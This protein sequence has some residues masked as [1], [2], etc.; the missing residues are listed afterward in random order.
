MA[1]FDRAWVAR[2]PGSDTVGALV[3][4][5]LS[6]AERAVIANHAAAC[7]GCH[8]LIEGL[9]ETGAHSE[10]ASASEEA[11]AGG[12]R[13]TDA[14]R[15]GRGTRVGRYVIGERLGAGG[16][17]IVHA[18]VDSELHRRV[19]VKLLRP[20]RHGQVS[21]DGRER[22]MREARSLARLSH[23]NV[24]TVFDVGEHQ[25]EL[26]IAMELVDGGS[27]SAWLRRAPRSTDEVIARM[28]DAGRG[29]AAAH[30]A[31]IVHRDIKPDNILVGLDGRVRVTD[32]GL[33]QYGD[34]TPAPYAATS[35]AMEESSVTLTRTGT[36]MGTPA[37]MA[38]EQRTRGTT[39][40][41]TDQWSFCATLH[42]ALSG[43][44]PLAA[45]SS[46]SA[47]RQRTAIS[48][49]RRLPRWVR[50]IVA[51]GLRDDP[52]ARWPSMHALVTALVRGRNRRRHLANA[53]AIAVA[54]AGFAI[55]I[56][57]FG[58]LGGCGSTTRRAS[59]RA[60]GMSSRG[61]ERS[62]A[63]SVAC[64]PTVDSVR[65][66]RLTRR[67]LCHPSSSPS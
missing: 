26:F 60:A 34:A 31:G 18:A 56:A 59:N 27:L 19:A 30:E 39:D 46:A 47:D 57:L 53:S 61:D 43:A 23:P 50:R 11:P 35:A 21:S 64:V 2:C 54:I 22:L 29:L 41:R 63:S 66:C 8:A 33:A 4:G 16:M 58:C 62:L 52:A 3:A 48:A 10:V 12:S 51:R 13:T 5:A 37:Y 67:R 55:G 17:G 40:A 6:D 7:D 65:R 28:I 20:D 49:G 9:V 1:N 44:R 25:G 42:E 38:P 45:R 36:C 32:F 24:V 14:L 15:V